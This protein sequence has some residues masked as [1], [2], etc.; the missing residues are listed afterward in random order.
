MDSEQAVQMEERMS[1]ANVDA[2]AKCRRKKEAQEGA[3]AAKKASKKAAAAA[4]L[5]DEDDDNA[6]NRETT[7]SRGGVAAPQSMPSPLRRQLCVTPRKTISSSS[8][9]P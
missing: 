3:V 2:N 1:K 7:A 6:G 4:S 9:S 5:A 8:S